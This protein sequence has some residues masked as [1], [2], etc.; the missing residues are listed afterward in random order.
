MKGNLP[1]GR[2]VICVGKVLDPGDHRR[3]R[4]AGTVA[5]NKDES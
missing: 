3:R 2:G 5:L 4:E 1:A